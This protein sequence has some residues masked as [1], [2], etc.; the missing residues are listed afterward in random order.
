MKIYNTLSR[1]LEE[2]KPIKSNEVSLY[3]CGPT[4]YHYAHIGNLRAFLFYDLL[5]RALTHNGYDVKHVMNIT[6]VGHLTDDADA[7]EDKMEKGARREGKTAWDVA[8]Y[9]TDAFLSDMKLLN[10]ISPT[11]QP[12]ATE[13]IEQ[14]IELVKQLE[15]KGYTYKTSTGIAYDTSKFEN[16]SKLSRMNIKDL[17]EGA[18]V[19]VDPEKRNLTDFY[20]W[21][22]SPT[23]HKRD[24]E[25]PSPWGVGFPGWHIECSAMAIDLL[26]ETIDIHCGGIDH[27]TVHHTNEIAQSEGATGKIFSHYWMHNNF[28]NI[29][30]GVKMSKSGDNFYTLQKVIDLGFEPMVFRYLTLTAHYR[31]EQEFSI[32]SLSSAKASL[33]RIYN[34]VHDAKDI[35]VDS[36]ITNSEWSTKFFE[37]INDDLNTPKALSEMY[38]MLGSDLDLVTK[39]KHL[40]YFDSVLGLNLLAEAK[41]SGWLSEDQAVEKFGELYSQRK[42]ARENK[43]WKL[44][45]EL[46]NKIEATEPGYVVEDFK[47]GQKIKLR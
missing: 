17:Q 12:K 15:E 36:M 10:I 42:T 46:R 33:N 26:G 13:F 9:Y 28:L 29:A 7:G 20:L 2:F 34:M 1:E 32:E 19:E 45:D 35:N 47:D 24:M 21:K 6:D 3:T 22:F 5:K 44:S 38:L 31:S 25:W 8:K 27:I 14:Q 11:F 18:R 40:I 43:D 30:G 37:V 16:Y 4:V 23:D 39:Q 41:K